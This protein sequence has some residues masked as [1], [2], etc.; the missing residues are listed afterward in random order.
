ML[1][2]PLAAVAE[3]IRRETG[4]AMAGRE[5]NALRAALRRVAPGL[6]P[7]AFMRAV[8]DPVRGRQLLERLID[9]VTVQETSFVRDRGQLDEIPWQRL[10]DGAH[11][12]G[13][14]VIRV[15]SVGCATGEEPYTLA[16]LAAEKLGP[17]PAPVD[18]LGTDISRS[19]LAAAAAAR[20]HERTVRGLDG[21]LRDRY[22][23]HHAD[24]S[25]TV[26]DSLR[27][28]VRFGRH[29]IVRDPVPPS[30]ETGF[31]LVT[32]RNVLIYF[33][34]PTAQRVLERLTMSLRP[35]GRLLVGAA[36]A[37]QRTVRIAHASGDA[38]NPPPAGKPAGR[39]PL[40]RQQ[41]RAQRLASALDAAGRGDRDEAL[42]RMAPL[43][44]TD[45]LDADV[46]FAHG[47]VTLEAG[48]PARAAA[49]FR[50]ALYA[51][52][53]FALAAFT[54]GCAYDALGNASAARRA[55]EQA[56]RTLRP[57][58]ARHDALL[59]QIDLG[60]IAGA[61]R[62]RLKWHAARS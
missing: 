33:E 35:G 15:W 32:C 37:L 38:E 22:L 45:P 30:G 4:I 29:N 53:A 34:A 26:R 11:A 49:A 2:V 44:I 51:D 20:Y 19:A 8:S 46:Q 3:L 5:N 40:G 41:T 60:D 24:G 18:V 42:T 17:G 50:R 12:A 56:L 59:E 48:D 25:Y 61:C 23:T 47:L 1:A 57:D 28:L 7:D 54:L 39:R 62:A 55:Y 6:P 9:E 31:D 16:L 52:P 27:R 36:D 58:D 21:G 43:L 13:S 14:A 10:R